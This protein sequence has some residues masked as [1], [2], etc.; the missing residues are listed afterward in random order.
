MAYKNK[1]TKKEYDKKYY[2]ENKE[3]RLNSL[4]DLIKDALESLKQLQGFCKSN[5]Y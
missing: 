4:K 1:E 3:K 2:E 5:D